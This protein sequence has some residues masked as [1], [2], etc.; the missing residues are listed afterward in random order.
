MH[1]QPI[2]EADPSWSLFR[3]D[4]SG[5]KDKWCPASPLEAPAQ[6][7]SPWYMACRSRQTISRYPDHMYRY[8]LPLHW[9]LHKP[10]I[11]DH[12]QR[13]YYPGWKY[14]RYYRNHSL[15]HHWQR[16][17]Q[18]WYHS[19]LPDN[20]SARSHHEEMHIQDPVHIPWKSPFWTSHQ[21]HCADDR[22]LPVPAV[23]WHH[24]YQDG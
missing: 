16:S 1:N 4:C 12:I 23:M 13:S 11:Q 14:L 3:L 9:Y 5:N 22:S 7:Y 20:P 15:H 2:P 24:R 21:R 8:D 17:H 6:N 10:D 19:L 18:P